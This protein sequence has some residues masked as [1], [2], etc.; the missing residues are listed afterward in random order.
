MRYLWDTHTF[1][2]WIAGTPKIRSQVRFI[3]EDEEHEPI[4]SIASL[5][6]ISVKN[7]L[8][9]LEIQGPYESII[10]DVDQNGIKILPIL[11]EHTVIQH[12]LPFHHRDPFDRI[13]IA[14]AIHGNMP[15]LSADEQFDLY[16]V[17]RVW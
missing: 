17:K 4:L 15:I 3:I 9:K 16:P 2:W 11:F 10:E 14:Q 8:G 1:L 6:E 13:L 7:A 5:W 12:S